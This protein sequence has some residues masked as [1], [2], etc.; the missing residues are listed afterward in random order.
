MMEPLSFHVEAT[1]LTDNR[2]HGACSED[3]QLKA[4]QKKQI[5][6]G[7]SQAGEFYKCARDHILRLAQVGLTAQTANTFPPA[8]TN[9]P[10]NKYCLTVRHCNK[11]PYADT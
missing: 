2:P 3:C 1:V 6:I 5:N 11:M 4:C 8:T 9:K 7:Q 10:D